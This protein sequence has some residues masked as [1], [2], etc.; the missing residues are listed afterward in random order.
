MSASHQQLPKEEEKDADL[1]SN[2]SVISDQSENPNNTLIAQVPV[3]TE[4]PNQVALTITQEAKR[5]G[6]NATVTYTPIPQTDDYLFGI[7]LNM[8]EEAKKKGC[9]SWTTV[10]KLIFV[11]TASLAAIFYWNYANACIYKNDKCGQWV[12]FIPGEDNQVWTLLISGGSGFAVTNMYF[13]A[14]AAERLIDFVKNKG[15]IKSAA[16]LTF[17]IALQVSALLCAGLGAKGAKPTDINVMLPAIAI[18]PTAIY[19]ATTATNSLPGK[20]FWAEI[21]WL[22]ANLSEYLNPPQ[23]TLAIKARLERH[24]NRHQFRLY[25]QRMAA[26]AKQFLTA[27]RGEI[28]EKPDAT[29][30][31]IITRN[32]AELSTK[33]K[34]II[35]KT[36]IEVLKDLPGAFVASTF[37]YGL[38]KNIFNQAAKIPVVEGSPL[39]WIITLI[40]GVGMFIPNLEL[41]IPIVSGLLG[42]LLLRLPESL[43][44]KLYPKTTIGITSTALITQSMSYAAI[45][46]L[47]VATYDLI[48]EAEETLRQIAKLGIILYHSAGMTKVG[49]AIMLHFIKDF[50]TQLAIHMNGLFDKLKWARYDEFE[51]DIYEMKP[52]QRRQLGITLCEEDEAER[53]EEA[54]V[55]SSAI[56]AEE[57][58]AKRQSWCTYFCSLFGRN[59]YKPDED[60]DYTLL[61]DNQTARNQS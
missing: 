20:Y 23:T 31:D 41:T 42:L 32:F 53:K 56:V 29:P 49:L 24:H 22:I 46:G 9:C 47:F 13:A 4:N 6:V 54:A 60:H 18:I 61:N 8:T 11:P 5:H 27:P 39:Q 2:D 14:K 10:L 30:R 12:S 44:L 50:T 58:P 33:E 57:K 7:K 19:A 15:P 34:S 51:K 43:A 59:T 35:F 28:E 17:Y 45:D 21:K 26:R 3:S 40:L 38:I 52:E 37:S 1:D 25:Q 55:N 16:L 48:P 36:M